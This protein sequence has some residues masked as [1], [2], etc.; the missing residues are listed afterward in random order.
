VST[1]DQNTERQLAGE[2]LD[3]IFTD[4]ASGK[5]TERPALAEL[6]AYVRAGDTVVVHSLDRLARNLEDLRAL[7]RTITGKGARVQFIK[8]SLTFTA[9]A[10]PMSQLIMNV[11]GAFAEF[12]RALIRERQRE[13]IALAKAKGV[14][15]GRKRAL[16]AEQILEIRKRVSEGA[17]KAALA[18]EL[19]VS[20]ETLHRYMR[21]EGKLVIM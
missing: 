8:E 2:T 12:E 5:D 7:V 6:V 13:G 16:T 17:K 9:E 11:M 4:H 3:R 1:L 21:Q 14:Y 10:S 19:G 20:R 15:R 18:R